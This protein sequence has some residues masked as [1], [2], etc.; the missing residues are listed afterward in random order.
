ML[1]R[2]SA[3]ALAAAVAMPA[4]AQSTGPVP[5]SGPYVGAE[6]GWQRDQ[7]SGSNS[8]NGVNLTA[9][10]NADGLR[11]G[12]FA[13]YDFRFG[14][15]G[16]FGIEV[17]ASGTTGKF[18]NFA[19]SGA[20]INVGR[21]F[22]VTARAGGLVNESTLLYVRG[23]YSNA[24]YSINEAGSSYAENRDGYLI[25]VGAEQALSPNVSARV[26]Y[27]YSKF[28]SFNDVDPVIGNTN[29]DLQRHVVKAGVA[30]RF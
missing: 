19:G 20:N 2:I 22:D 15:A 30:F 8:S 5:F 29:V 7:V 24:R 18:N 6:L 23:G 9:N 25:G 3:A 13:G 4:L 11:Y 21:T 27:N 1:A 28:G 12:G 16:V 26:E 10:I 17:G 14:G